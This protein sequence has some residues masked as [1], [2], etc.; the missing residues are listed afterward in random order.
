MEKLYRQRKTQR[1]TVEAYAVCICF[2]TVGLQ[3][4]NC[5]PCLSTPSN[6]YIGERDSKN[7]HYAPTA[8]TSANT[9]K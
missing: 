8:S 6:A 3:E 4:V 5:N 7:K 1:E 9:K 2:C